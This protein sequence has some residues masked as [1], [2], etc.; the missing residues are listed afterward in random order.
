MKLNIYK[1]IQYNIG[2]K[3]AKLD[4]KIKQHQGD[5]AKA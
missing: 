4:T 3:H 5:A 2:K 1:Y